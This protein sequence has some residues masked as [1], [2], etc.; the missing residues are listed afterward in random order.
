MTAFR[1]WHGAG[2]GA[3]HGVGRHAAAGLRWNLERLGEP[4]SLSGTVV[5]LGLP[6]C[7]AGPILLDPARIGGTLPL[8]LV[9]AL[10][11]QLCLLACFRIGSRIIH[12]PGTPASRPWL[13]ML[14]ILVGV[15][16]RGVVLALAPSLLGLTT[17]IDWGYRIGSGAFA[18]FGSFVVLGL[19]VTTYRHHHRLA[20]ELERTRAAAEQVNAELTAQLQ[21][22]ETV[23][24]EQVQETVLPL[25]RDIDGELERVTSG[26]STVDVRASIRRLIDEDLRPL[27]DRLAGGGAA[28]ADLDPRGTAGAQVPLPSRMP[29]RGLVT[30]ISFG[31]LA[32][33]AAIPQGLRTLEMPNAVLFPLGAWIIVTLLLAALRVGV[34]GWAPALWVGVAITTVAGAIA[35]AASV[36]LLNAIG[37]GIPS[38]LIPVALLVGGVWAGLLSLY[39]AVNERRALTEEELR[40]SV[41]R[42]Q[43]VSSVLRRRSYIAHR[44]LSLVL[45]GPIQSALH[46]AA[47]RLAAVPEP[48]A[49]LIATI[50]RDISDAVAQL[51]AA[52]SPYAFLVDTLDDIA[53]LWDG[54]CTVRWTMDHQTVRLLATSPDAAM[55][56]AEIARECVTN[57]IKHGGATDIW[58]TLA[59][60]GDGVLIT[61]LDDGV[62]VAD[63]AVSGVG[64]RML[65]ELTVDWSRE[66]QGRGTKVIARVAV[67]E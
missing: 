67:S 52:S 61:A 5:L 65:D 56:A 15:L 29:L 64:S 36:V 47:L 19:L 55:S 31:L 51:D 4:G 10:A 8:W 59:R 18:L 58:I 3:G 17:Q 44:K 22:I 14:V 28:V 16:A 50:R 2:H 49:A 57:A 48:D 40:Q 42:L 34:R 37:M 32:G 66:R 38:A 30:P 6:I 12:R 53:E 45:H 20:A 26:V 63:G 54:T 25:I 13:T 46:A 7:L 41:R 39:R 33:L 24:A 9:L 21:D 35:Y 62:G 1:N 23:V 60:S 11:A 27:S 43:L